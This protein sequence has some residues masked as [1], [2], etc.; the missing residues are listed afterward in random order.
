[1]KEVCRNVSEAHTCFKQ[2]FLWT[3]AALV[4]FIKH[5]FSDCVEKTF[6]CVCTHMGER[7]EHSYL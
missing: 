3:P 7:K 4:P 1:M 2:M 5:E 6:G